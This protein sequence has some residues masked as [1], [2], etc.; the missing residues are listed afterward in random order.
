MFALERLG[1][2]LRVALGAGAPYMVEVAP[3]CLEWLAENHAKPLE[4]FL[5]E[6]EGQFR[7][8][9]FEFVNPCYS[10]P[11]ALTVSGESNLKQFEYGLRVLEGLG[12]PC[13]TYYCSEASYHPQVPQILRGFGIGH[14]SL[15][16]RLLGTCPTTP[17]GHVDWVGLDGTS[18]PALT[19]LPGVFNG[20]VW[21]GTFF[22][23]IPNLLFQA[24]ARPFLP[25][26]VYSNVED[27][28]MPL[29]HAEAVWRVSSF[30]PV[31]GEFVTTAELFERVE[32]DGRF[33]FSRDQF[34]LGDYIFRPSGLF[35]GLSDC[36]AA[37]LTA[38]AA[39][40]LHSLARGE[41]VP[42]ERDA[43]LDGA[44]KEMLLAQA[45][46]NFAVPF[47]RTGDYSAS[48]L[49]PEEYA[50]LGLEPGGL[51]I[52][53]VSSN[54]LE[55]LTAR[56][57]QF[58]RALLEQLPRGPGEVLVFNPTCFAREDLVEV[59]L[60]PGVAAG[61]GARALYDAGGRAVPFDLDEQEGKVA[62]IASVPP[63]AFTTYK[64]SDAA[65]VEGR[66][67]GDGR[68]G[69]FEF[70]LDVG[71]G[72]NA[73][74]VSKGGVEQFRLVFSR[75]LGGKPHGLVVG[76]GT[77][78]RVGAREVFL[79]GDASGGFHFTVAASQASGGRLLRFMLEDPRGL[80]DEIALVP[81]DFRSF[82]EVLVN[83]PFG[84]EATTR[85]RIQ[86]LDFIWLQG[87]A[88]GLLY[89]QKRSQLF[90][91]DHERFVVRN[92]TGGKGTFEFAVAVTGDRDPREAYA[93]RASFK[94][95]LVALDPATEPTPG[96]QV[97]R[98]G[99]GGGESL[100]TL[101]APGPCV[102]TNLWSRGGTSYARL[103]SPG[104]REVEVGLE[105]LLVGD[106]VTVVDL[107]LEGIREVGAGGFRVRPWE[108]L[109]IGLGKFNM[110]SP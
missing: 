48:Q 88:A 10:Q 47:T 20:E 80:V 24:V 93:A 40:V 78:G 71:S 60:P 50:A 92:S 95:P 14:A 59:T 44:W 104:T 69:S 41:Q 63:Y 81:T 73:I 18:V 65:D 105:G 12:I 100:L 76:G 86:S 70:E 64:F 84:V 99:V 52:S 33:Q 57:G 90:R 2:T 101:L 37:I 97:G 43:F 68:A 34:Y 16:T 54:L 1:R 13:D 67:G 75:H 56:C 29:A 103:F 30:E 46:D 72:G 87:G 15:R 25:H 42:D 6:F 94:A 36:E 3:C 106:T 39:R 79:G 49:S 8:G 35:G 53:E 27:F 17:S 102:V 28:I 23:E 7:D 107:K 66:E 85:S 38:E 11:Y 89:M 96:V 5:S 51:T 61:A 4:R 9:R 77:R 62:F 45:H 98:E 110:R 82:S 108:V 91:V 74:V 22:W 21:H 83:Y 55:R 58:A 32:K 19:D 109:T 26:V 31:L